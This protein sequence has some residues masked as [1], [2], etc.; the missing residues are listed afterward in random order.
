MGQ[1][2]ASALPARPSN[3]TWDDFVQC[4]VDYDEHEVHAR[5]WPPP[6]LGNQGGDPSISLPCV[7]C[8]TNCI[9]YQGHAT[10]ELKGITV[11]LPEAVGSRK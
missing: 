4:E 11:V 3:K 7:R 6:R 9:V 2:D 8:G 10:G 1:R 5:T